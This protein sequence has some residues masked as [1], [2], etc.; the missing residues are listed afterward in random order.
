[1]IYRT[2]WKNKK[3]AVETSSETPQHSAVSVLKA[4][5]ALP[6]DLI[7]EMRTEISEMK[8]QGREQQD[9]L[10]SVRAKLAV[11]EGAD[12]SWKQEGNRHQFEVLH[13]ILDTSHQSKVAYST[14]GITAGEEKLNDFSDESHQTP[15]DSRYVTTRVE[16][17][18][19][20]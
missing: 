9:E 16:H 19:R 3:S 20:I 13:K 1:M 7:Q 17:C 2:N 6:N 12:F 4:P 14:R 5:E 8:K 11:K 10:L 18:R 15:Q